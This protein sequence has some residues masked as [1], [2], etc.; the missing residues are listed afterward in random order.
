MERVVVAR[1]REGAGREDIIAGLAYSVV[2]NYLNRV[3]GSRPVGKVVFCQGMPFASDALAAAETGTLGPFPFGAVMLVVLFT[4][5]ATGGIAPYQYKWW[6]WNGSAWSL[7]R[8]WGT[9]NTFSW[10]PG[11]AGTYSIQVWVRN[12]GTTAEAPEATGTAAYTVF[13]SVGSTASPWSYQH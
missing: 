3:K 2:Q 10:T 7:G 9:G 4:A 1:L 12:N 5:T 8:D 13:G 11:A 6:V